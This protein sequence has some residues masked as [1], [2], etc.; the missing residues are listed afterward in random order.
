MEILF[1]L[2]GSVVVYTVVGAITAGIVD[3]FG[4]L[5]NEP[6]KA[7]GIF[8]FGVFW[9]IFYLVLVYGIVSTAIEK[10]RKPK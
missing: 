8:F 6:D 9:P 10:Y 3:G 2:I 7:T 1:W 5:N 4:F